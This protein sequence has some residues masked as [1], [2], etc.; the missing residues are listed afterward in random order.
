MNILNLVFNWEMAENVF[1]VPD[2]V[3][4]NYLKLASGKA[5]KVLLYVLKYKNLSEFDINTAANMLG[6]TSEDVEDA[7]S[8]WEQTGLF[9]ERNSAVIVK[10]EE[11]YT[12]TKNIVKEEKLT[13]RESP[14]KNI[15]PKEIAQRIEDSKEV[16]FLFKSAEKSLARA[17]TYTDQK[18]LIW[19]HDY[20]GLETDIILMLI[21]F[22]ISID[23][24]SMG[25][26]ERVAFTWHDK[27]IKTHEQAEYE[28][29]Q[30]QKYYSLEGK[31]KSLLGINRALSSKEKDYVNSWAEMSID[32]DLVSI[33]YDKT[34]DATGKL[35]FA[36][37]N[38]ILTEWYTKGIKTKAEIDKIDIEFKEKNKATGLSSQPFEEE[39][40]SYNLDL[41]I[42]HAINNTPKIKET[43]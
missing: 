9:R 17:L 16:S 43:T 12:V 14:V 25:F 23:K 38:K 42:Q 41:L 5:V 20:L 21:G 37:L 27:N 4:D 40:H 22:C 28:I 1:A 11:N 10:A 24:A 8:Y 32:I 26:I 15:S 2:C 13:F 36:Y 31:I 30:L 39:Q 19:I 29:L 35:S 3:V 7:L 33:A 34:I 6:I 18:T